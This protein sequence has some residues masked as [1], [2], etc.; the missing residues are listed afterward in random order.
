MERNNQNNFKESFKQ[1]LLKQYELEYNPDK[2]GKDDN[3]YKRGYEYFNNKKDI[4]DEQILDEIVK[5]YEDQPHKAVILIDAENIHYNINRTVNDTNIDKH[6]GETIKETLLN[7]FGLLGDSYHI[8]NVLFVIFSQAHAGPFYTHF[9]TWLN[10]NYP[11]LNILFFTD[12]PNQSEVDD[13][14]LFLAFRRL[15]LERKN[16]YVRTNDNMRWLN[17]Q[18][19]RNDEQK[20]VIIKETQKL[21][22]KKLEDYTIDGS[23]HLKKNTQDDST[24]NEIEKL[25][26]GAAK[27]DAAETGATETVAAHSNKRPRTTGGGKAVKKTV[28]KPVKKTAKKPVKKPVKKREKKTVK[29]AVKKAVK[30]TAKKNQKVKKI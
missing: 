25:E 1:L 13:I 29:K 6:S 14:L 20:T 7:Y 27:T 21:L 18:P 28:K 17:I 10:K 23:F 5:T 2:D 30:K 12:A 22:K 19:D 26:T 15:V 24:A 16:V 8:E 3:Y 4:I 9:Y 11:N